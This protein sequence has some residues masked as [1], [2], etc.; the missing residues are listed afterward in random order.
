M[1]ITVKLFSTLLEYLP[2]DSDGNEFEIA[3]STGDSVTPHTL[4]DQYQ[5]PRAEAQVVMVNGEF[6]PLEN[7]DDALK[8]GDVLSIWPSIQGG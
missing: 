4:I 5:L 1:K 8:D 6:V 3:V 7:R 2:P